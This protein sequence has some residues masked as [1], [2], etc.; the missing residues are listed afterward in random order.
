MPAPTQTLPLHRVRFFDH[1]P[2][3]IVA[4]AF[5]PQPLPVPR[6]PASVKGKA[7]DATDRPELGALVVARENGEVEIWKYSPSEEGSLGN[8][9]LYKTL[10]PTLTHPTISVMALALRDPENFHSKPYAVPRV[11]DLRLFVAGSESTELTERC[12]E[13][14]RVLQTY[15]I[16]S[17]PLWSL[18]VSPTQQLLCLT[19][20]SPALHFVSIPPPLL[21]GSVTVLEPAPSHLLRSETLPSRTRTVSVAWGLPKLVQ[22][23]GEWS[24]R[25]TYLLTGNSD[26]SFRRWEL[27]VPTGGGGGRVQI[28][29]R[30]VVEKIA[31]GKKGSHKGTI[32]WGVGVLPD[33]TF[34]TSDSLGTVAFWDPATMA[35]RQSFRPHKADGMCLT[36]GPGGR[37]VFTSGP[38]QKVCQFSAITQANGTTQWALT[39][40]KR[41][42]THDV[43]A[44]AVFPP[45]LPLAANS[46]LTPPALNPNLAPILASGGW[47]MVPTLTPAAPPDLL[48]QRLRNPLGKEKGGQGNKHI[49]FEDAFP[50]RLSMF[51]GQRGAEH[52][53]VSRGARL[54]VG[55][56]DRSVGIWRILDDERGWEKALEMDL[57][58]RT[59]L[60]SHAIS[61]DGQWLAV[62]D[63]YETK[64]FRLVISGT[65]SRPM[66][67]RDFVSDLESAPELAELDLAQ[68]GCGASALLF[69][70]D[71]RRLVLSLAASA[72]TVVLELDDEGVEVVR[73]FAPQHTLVGGRSI[74][75]GK[76]RRRMS[77]PVDEDV[78]MESD[79]EDT[80]AKGPAAWITALAASDD[81]Q[82]LATSDLE[83]KVTVFNLD[84]LQLHA[85]LPSFAAPPASIAFTPTHPLL[86]LVHAG[87]ALQFF[88]LDARRLLPP[89]NQLTSLNHTLRGLHSA[90]H[91]AAWEPSR[92]SPRAARLVVWSND[93]LASIRL[94]LDLVA[95]TQGRGGSATPSEPGTPLDSRSLRKKR[96]REAREALEASSPSSMPSPSSP[97]MLLS[98]VLKTPSAA[99]DPDFVKVATD[100]FRSVVGAD[101]LADGELVL[102]ERPYAD[103]VSELPP[104][105]WT[106]KYGRS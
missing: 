95:R 72:H 74:Q 21:P 8:W 78:D 24:W 10:P 57:R 80:P 12:L 96:A 16:P 40:T 2:S 3:P 93:W 34:V 43:R 88:H 29:G 63:L 41:L 5:P 86:A 105:F 71:S 20:N 54:V 15:P 55:R 82:W 42:H 47:D 19:T 104:A 6:D 27:P 46:Q 53:A 70:P 31:K 94:D 45:Y 98:R 58:L 7:R 28:K 83:G 69:T 33:G 22:D 14:G 89:S 81:A 97:T 25:D 102:V 1:T 11:E 52:I 90:A 68:K 73:S 62:S 17:P 91:G 9:V 65:T 87:N 36:I 100:R 4:L 56:K 50:R 76:A 84:T 79:E 32:V 48:A 39:A 85:L 35:Q 30:A 38:D 37:T 44:L 26:S 92:T 77:A 99:N 106:G 51:G 59:N 64:L 61:Q 49:V 18:S 103:F 66:R 60:I 13:T 23:N 101:W 67:V 75:N